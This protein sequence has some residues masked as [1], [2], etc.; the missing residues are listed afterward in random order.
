M[1]TRGEEKRR[2]QNAQKRTLVSI[3]DYI[4]LAYLAE[5]YEAANQYLQYLVST[6]QAKKQDVSK[7]HL[8]A[9]LNTATT[10]EKLNERIDALKDLNISTKMVFV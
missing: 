10:I 2:W 6:A 1:Q 3:S 4:Q 9:A 5:D 8:R 7:L